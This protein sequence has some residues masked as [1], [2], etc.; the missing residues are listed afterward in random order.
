MDIEWIRSGLNSISGFFMP[1]AQLQPPAA[2][3]RVE[4]I[5]R[6]MLDALGGPGA[7]RHSRLALRIR[8]AQQAQL[9]WDLRGDLMNAACVQYGESRARSLMARVDA[10]FNGAVPATWT[11]AGRHAGRGSRAVLGMEQPWTEPF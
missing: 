3:E 10:E 2:P 6:S 5:R 9:L 4:A 8:V 7:A 11:A 1:A